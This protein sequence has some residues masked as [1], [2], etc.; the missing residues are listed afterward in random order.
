M[1]NNI[2]NKAKNI[3]FNNKK[4]GLKATNVQG[5]I[6]EL[7][8]EFFL[9]KVVTDTTNSGGCLLTN[10]PYYYIPVAAIVT[11]HTHREC[12][13]F[14]ANNYHYVHVRDAIG[15]SDISNVKVTVKV[16]YINP[17]IKSHTNA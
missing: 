7:I 15:S 11:S 17:L 10:L 6:D 13:F 9:T 3:L 14:V 8:S 5:A 12:T 4:S 2:F 16:Y 1:V